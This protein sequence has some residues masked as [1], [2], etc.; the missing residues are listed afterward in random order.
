MTFV[1]P[2][3]LANIRTTSADDNVGAVPTWIASETAEE[4]VK[5]YPRHNWTSCFGQAMR[6]EVTV[7]PWR[8]ELPLVMLSP[9]MPH[10]ACT[11]KKMFSHT[12]FFDV[13]GI[14]DQVASNATA[15]P[16]ED[17]E[18]AAAS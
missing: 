17:A 4:I 11:I 12:T 7:K 1:P 9:G 8:C 10:T 5:A 2:W 3:S 15:K 18:A 6:D 16:F 13:E 14:W